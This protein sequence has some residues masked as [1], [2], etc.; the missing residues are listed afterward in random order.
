MTP[1]Q[2][3]GCD[4]YSQGLFTAGVYGIEDAIKSYEASN[5]EGRSKKL[6]YLIESHLT[7]MLGAIRIKEGLDKLYDT[8]TI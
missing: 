6:A 1:K 3:Y 7:N 5:E 8:K 4:R 2:K